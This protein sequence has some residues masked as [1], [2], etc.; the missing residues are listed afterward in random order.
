MLVVLALLGLSNLVAVYYLWKQT[1]SV[2]FRL[3]TYIVNVQNEV[4]RLYSKE[5]E[6]FQEL[7]KSL[8]STNKEIKNIPKEVVVKNVL[9]LP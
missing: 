8:E 9:K 2:E 3:L 5:S 4:N 7:V 6:N 1:K